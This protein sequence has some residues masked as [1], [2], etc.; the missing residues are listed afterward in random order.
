MAIDPFTEQ[1]RWMMEQ[2]IRARGIRNER[3]LAAMEKV[4]RHLFVPENMRRD[5]V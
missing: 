5:S 4:P 3:V 2:Q 1:R